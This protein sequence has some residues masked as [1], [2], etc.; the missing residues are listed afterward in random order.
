MQEPQQ[1]PAPRI[2]QD[3]TREPDQT[4]PLRQ[5][6]LEFL[7]RLRDMTDK[8]RDIS[9]VMFHGSAASERELHYILATDDVARELRLLRSVA[10]V[11]TALL[12]VIAVA[13]AAIA[14]AYYAVIT[15]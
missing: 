12:L 13:A 14:I 2:R 8:Q 11:A 7:Q 4:E 5:D 9:R 6:H 10:I 1:R 15:N 3:K